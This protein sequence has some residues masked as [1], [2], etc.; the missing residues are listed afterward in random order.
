MYNFGVIVFPGSNCD[1]DSYHVIKHVM[2]QNCEFVWHEDVNLDRFDCIIIP[3]GFSYGDYLRTGAIASLSPI[4]ESVEKFASRGGP[5]LGT[6]NGFQI[7]VEAGLLPGVLIRN[8][9]LEFVCRWV[10]IRVENDKTPFT[11]SLKEG[12]VLRIPV[13]HG[14]GSY[15]CTE[16]VLKSLEDN[17]QI[18]FRYCDA[19]GNITPE[20]NPNGSIG[21]IAGIC[22]KAG[23]VLGMMPHPERCSESV[24]GGADGRLIFESVISWLGLGQKKAKS[25]AR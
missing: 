11:G 2:G 18:V 14:E 3:G 25:K 5:V 17:S 1:H 15:Y 24:L 4:M 13:A 16:D 22:S 20:S 9:S 12:D 21:N 10:D 23:N 19:E 6:C 7:L 8:S